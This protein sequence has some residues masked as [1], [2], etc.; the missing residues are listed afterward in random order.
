MSGCNLDPLGEN[1]TPAYADILAM[2]PQYTVE[3]LYAGATASAV[4]CKCRTY[5]DKIIWVYMSADEYEELLSIEL[6]SGML[7]NEKNPVS[8]VRIRIHGNA[9]AV[10]DLDVKMPYNQSNSL[11]TST[12]LKYKSASEEDYSSENMTSDSSVVFSQ[13]V[14]ELTEVYADVI[15]LEDYYKLNNS[16]NPFSVT[17]YVC[18]GY[19]VNAGVVWVYIDADDYENITENYDLSGENNHIRIYGF[20]RLADDLVK[21]LTNEIHTNKIIEYTHVE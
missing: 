21:D 5:D 17:G 15:S 3:G 16:L 9:T 4:L 1:G 6:Q 18:K 20:S 12:V 11:K 10:G 14:Q 2:V 13:D 8:L 19:R 7:N